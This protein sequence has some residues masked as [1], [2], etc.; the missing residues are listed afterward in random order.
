MHKNSDNNRTRNLDGISIWL[1]SIC[2]IHCLTLPLITISIPLFGKYMEGHFHSLMLF[3]VIP[4]SIVALTKG[5]QNHKNIIIVIFG[6]FGGI[7]VILG[8][9]YIHYMSNYS[10]D[11]LITISGSMVL[12]LAH[13]FNNRSSH[14]HSKSCR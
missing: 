11:T 6:L 5:Y 12:A 10:S 9:T 1:S 3:I 8:A 2:L 13:F 14:Y 7:G 4:V